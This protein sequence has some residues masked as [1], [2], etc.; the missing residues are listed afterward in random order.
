M[1]AYETEA[2]AKMTLSQLRKAQ[3]LVH[4]QMP[5]AYEQQNERAMIQLQEWDYVYTDAI[6]RKVW[7]DA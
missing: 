3:R 7:G 1:N 6:Y 4:A 5:L 2:L